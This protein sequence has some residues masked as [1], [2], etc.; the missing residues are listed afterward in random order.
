M[1]NLI[2]DKMATQLHACI[3]EARNMQPAKHL[4]IWYFI[5]LSKNLVTAA[6]IITVYLLP[7]ASWN[8]PN[9]NSIS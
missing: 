9:E 5:P 2:K 6:D 4:K 3:L 8:I 7:C 1:I